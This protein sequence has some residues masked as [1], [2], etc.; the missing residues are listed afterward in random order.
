MPIAT[1]AL[2]LA[3]SAAGWRAAAVT[4]RGETSVQEAA[5]FAQAVEAGFELAGE[6]RLDQGIA[7]SVPITVA[8]P[9]RVG[10]FERMCL[11]SVDEEELAGMV[12]LQFEKSLPYPV[13]EASIGVQILE[14]SHGEPAQ[15]T[16]L[17]CC[18]PHA[19]AETVCAPLL[20]RQRSP[21]RLT[22]W[23]MQVA[24]QA[25]AGV[26]ACGIWRE[27]EAFV[28]GIFEDRRLG[29][30]E[31]VSLACEDLAGSLSRALMSAGMAGAPLG[32]TEV[33]LEKSLAPLADAVAA[34]LGAPVREIEWQP[35]PEA[36]LDLTPEPWRAAAA[37]RERQG[38][39]R[40]ELAAAG[41][42]YGVL[43]VS[44]LIFLGLESGRLER[45][46]KQTRL[47]QPQMEAVLD[48]QSRWNALAPA[49]DQRRYAVELLYQAFQSLP[50][51]ETRITRF[52]LAPGQ[53][54]LQGEAPDAR[55]AVMCAE[56]LR[57]RPELAGF[58][59]ESG[60]PVILPNEHA[61]FGISGK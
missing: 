5:S 34:A 30:V 42:V 45:V 61:Q 60:Q 37:R 52:E 25:P 9:A 27:E 18:L 49:V 24:A 47:L 1:A 20:Q 2:T 41:G 28:F 12:R 22:L 48:Q 56:N 35:D 16:L 36:G 26:L 6:L 11:P 43:L 15:T 7:G 3:P 38:R 17:A 54:M 55:Q 57:K 40:K 21:Q 14:R 44:A 31:M 39:R 50:T 32:F 8:L 46:R 29:F 58:K 19:A 4:P 23:A 33:L 53:F 51:P 10:V 13:E 59:F